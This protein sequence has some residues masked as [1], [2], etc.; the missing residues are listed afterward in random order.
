MHCRLD[1]WHRPLAGEMLR[2]VK[3]Y[4]GL[5]GVRV[6]LEG[7]IHKGSTKGSKKGFWGL[8]LAGFKFGIRV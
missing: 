5:W 8:G 3:E 2:E 7:S 1:P 6:P 4:S